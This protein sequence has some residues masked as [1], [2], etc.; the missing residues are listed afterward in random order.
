MA[1]KMFETIKGRGFDARHARHEPA[2]PEMFS[3]SFSQAPAGVV[4]EKILQAG[5]GDVNVRQFQVQRRRG[6]N[7][8]WNEGSAATGIEING[9]ASGSPSF[10]NAGQSGKFFKQRGRFMREAEAQ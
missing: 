2:L 1:A 7:D 8:L 9:P 3:S 10:R 4:E 5:L 6:V